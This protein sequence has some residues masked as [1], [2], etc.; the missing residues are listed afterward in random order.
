MITN[1]LSKSAV[2]INAIFDNMTNEVLKKIPDDFKEFF[3]KI[4]SETYMFKYDKTKSLSEQQLLPKTKGILALI[5]RD[6]LC[7]D[8]E[9]KK[10]IE[11][12]KNVLQTIELKKIEKYNPNDIFKKNQNSY[13]EEILPVIYNPDS[14]IKR[15]FNKIKRIFLK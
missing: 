3:K 11:H 12:C 6:Y 7:N 10:Y 2:E 14:L 9:K 5:Y 1:E 13:Q 15:I 4:S 8:I